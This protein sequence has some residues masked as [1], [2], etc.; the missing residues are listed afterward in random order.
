VTLT[1]DLLYYVWRSKKFEHKNL[2]T[3]EGETI[4]I[5]NYG[6]RNLSSGP[7]FINAKIKIGNVVWAG[8]VEM[9]VLA[10]DW[11]RHN[12]DTDP[13]YN[14][15]ILHILY[16]EDKKLDRSIPTLVLKDI[17]PSDLMH[18]YAG[19]ME[20]TTWIPCENIIHK[21]DVEKFGIWSH[22]I[23]L[24]RLERKTNNIIYTSSF[25]NG[26]WQSVLYEQIAKYFGANQNTECF[27]TLANRLPLGTIL[28]NKNN[29]L[30]IESIV[31]GVAGLLNDEVDD[32]YYNQLKAEFTFQKNKYNLVPI[33]KVEWRNFGMYA[34]GLPTFRLA[35]FAGLL[36]HYDGIF[37]KVV[38]AN[39]VVEIKSLF[40][41]DKVNEYWTT[42]YTFANESKTKHT[43]KLTS[44]FIDRLI[45]NATLPTLFL[46]AKQTSNTDLIE[47]C[48]DFLSDLKAEDNTIVERW[49]ALGFV[50][51]NALHSQ[52]LIEL[53]TKYCDSKMCLACPVGIDLFKA[54]D[55]LWP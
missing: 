39:N 31:F 38:F 24:E 45:I 40:T 17:I 8:H 5:I 42:H 41:N 27:E 4:E 9:H 16:D 25:Q 18:K 37:D 11:T 53:K 48:T 49:K 33:N 32:I 30:A 55:I 15:V 10:S 22:A 26:D 7:D 44:S 12:H 46:Y 54:N 50:N 20:A 13:A 28:K 19:L 51:K 34:S 35:Q 3:T 14:N 43:T 47:K 29:G 2:L 52:A 6:T 36:M 21:V 23:A 1:E